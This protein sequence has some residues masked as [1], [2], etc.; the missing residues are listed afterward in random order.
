[1]SQKREQITI[2]TTKLL[3]I[4]IAGPLDVFCVPTQP[5]YDIPVFKF[6]ALMHASL[7]LGIYEVIYSSLTINETKRGVA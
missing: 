7:P 1:M 3:N 4:G 6:P 2:A 5:E